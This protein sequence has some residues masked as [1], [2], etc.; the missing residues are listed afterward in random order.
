[1]PEVQSILSAP[2][3]VRRECVLALAWAL[4]G[5]ENRPLGHPWSNQYILAAVARKPAPLTLADLEA[6]VAGAERVPFGYVG[7]GWTIVRV[8]PQFRHLYRRSGSTERPEVATLI[9]RAAAQ[10][11]YTKDERRL[12]EIVAR[13]AARN[14]WETIDDRDDVGPRLKAALQRSGEATECLEELL[15]LARALPASGRPSKSWKARAKKL[16][17]LLDD[18]HR[19]AADLIKAVLDARDVEIKQ[20]D[21]GRSFTRLLFFAG[22]NEGLVCG[23]IAFIGSMR[24]DSLVG[25]LRQLATKSL[26]DPNGWELRLANA[27][28]RAIA[29][30]GSDLAVRELA[31]VQRAASHGGVLRDVAKAIDAIAAQRGVTAD[32]LIEAGVETHGLASDGTIARPIEGGSAVLKVEDLTARVCFVAPDGRRRAS[33]PTAVRELGAEQISQLRDLAKEVRKTLASE[34]SRL[35]RMMIASRLWS[36]RDWE[37]LYLEHPVTGHL[38]QRLIWRFTPADQELIGLPDRAG[39]VSTAGGELLKIPRRASVS[40]WHPLSSTADHVH[41]WRMRLLSDLVVQPFRQ[42]FRELY[43]LSPGEEAASNYS[44][45]FAGHVFRRTQARTLMKKRGWKPVPAAWW[46]DGIEHGVAR[47][48]YDDDQIRA[49]FF[50]DP[51]E[52]VEPDESGVYRYCTSDQVRFFRGNTDDAV[53]LADVPPVLFSEVMRDVDLFVSVTSIGAD[54]DWLDRKEGRRFDKNWSDFSF[55]PL[56]AAGEIRY[57]VLAEL[58]PRLAIADRCEFDDSYLVVAGDLR[59]YRIHLGSG[60]VRMSPTGAQLRISSPPNQRAARLLL[61]IDDDQ[62]LIRILASALTL[63]NDSAIKNDELRTRI[64]GGG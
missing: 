16:Q 64:G 1:M 12:S 41:E 60:L 61:P 40:L 24:L 21:L 5:S 57:Q 17:G 31:T 39:L 23:L 20:T 3:P 9:V 50:F 51:I 45:R 33:F 8:T 15:L 29:E 52:D 53:E 7:P 55:G 18:P 43:L 59:T 30:N 27:C 47:R 14:A 28:V 54:P 34:R 32:E 4:C 37:R 6:L 63:A 48:L 58:V 11:H 62:V 22:D 38:T 35:D 42:A 56:A 10:V 13:D 2:G 36:V 44:N 19:V 46:D 49:E 25:D 26:T